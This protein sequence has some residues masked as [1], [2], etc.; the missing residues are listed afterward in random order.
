MI[1]TLTDRIYLHSSEEWPGL[2]QS[3]CSSKL[4]L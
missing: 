4:L 2:S 3:N 1:K